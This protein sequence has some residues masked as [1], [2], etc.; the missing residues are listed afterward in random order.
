MSALLA[1]FVKLRTLRSTGWPLAL[2]APVAA[3]MAYVVGLSFGH[4]DPATVR[5]DATFAS[6]YS[7]SFAQ[8]ALV[9]FA[10]VA[11]AGEYGSGTIRASLSA[12][13]DRT[14][15]YLAKMST[16]ALCAAAASALSVAASFAAAQSGLSP[17][18]RTPLSAPGVL[19]TAT[20]A[21]LYLVLIALFAAGVAQ[22]LR[23]TALS[24]GILL[25]LF[26]LGSQ[27]LGNIPGIWRVAQFLPDQAGVTILHFF[28]DP[29]SPDYNR[30][31][32]PWG[33]LA[34]LALWSAVALL[35]GYL[36]LRTRDA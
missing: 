25:P 30:A 8:L 12:V 19:A 7:L 24:L 22:A 18:L 28:G 26:F 3:A 5:F 36:T 13:P 1:E 11:V 14:A 4:A 2:T 20:G 21:W 32:G 16:V 34:I 33:G 10:V 6:F 29:A 35:G 9:V 15:F 23:S 27:G 31:F 17:R